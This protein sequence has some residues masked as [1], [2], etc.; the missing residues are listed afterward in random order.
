MWKL[1][2]KSAGVGCPFV[3]QSEDKGEVLAFGLQHARAWHKY[4]VNTQLLETIDKYI[5]KL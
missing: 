2:C 5:T 4:D 3:I 1:E